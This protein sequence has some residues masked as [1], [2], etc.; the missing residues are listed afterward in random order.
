MQWV[1]ANTPK[2]SRFLL[3]TLELSWSQDSGSEWSPV[4]ARRVSVGTVQGT[5]WLPD[6]RF[7]QSVEPCA[8]LQEG[9]VADAT[10][11]ERWAEGAELA[12]SHIYI[13]KVEWKVPSR[14]GC[15]GGLRCSL[16]ASPS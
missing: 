2:D 3:V 14:Q 4:L 11:L 12:F 8:D 1:A 15:V 7:E 5:E 10:C 13:S 9:R 6:H 16:A